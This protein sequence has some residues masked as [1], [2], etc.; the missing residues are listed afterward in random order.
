[1][2]TLLVSM[3]LLGSV[4]SAQTATTINAVNK[5][6]YGANIG[7]MDWRGD[8]NNGAVIG[9]FVCAGNLEAKRYFDL[10]FLP[11]RAGPSVQ[12]LADGKPLPLLP[13]PS[14]WI[15]GTVM[16]ARAE[17]SDPAPQKLELKVQ[18]EVILLSAR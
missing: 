8:T 13:D 9:E 11:E 4:L 10:Y 12:L 3:L 6:S 2:K 14:R 15:A 18:G 17:L 7:W 1:M 16:V 5:F